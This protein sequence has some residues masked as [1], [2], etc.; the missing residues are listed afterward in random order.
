MFAYIQKKKAQ[1]QLHSP[2][3]LSLPLSRL[4]RQTQMKPSGRLND[5]ERLDK[6][7][8]DTKQHVVPSHCEV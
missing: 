8:L 6:F 2:T 3:K 7:P 5:H 4:K 1:M